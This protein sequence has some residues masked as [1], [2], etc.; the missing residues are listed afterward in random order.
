MKFFSRGW[1]FIISALFIWCVQFC[2]PF[3]LLFGDNILCSKASHFMLWLKYESEWNVC[4]DDVNTLCISSNFI[5]FGMTCVNGKKSSVMIW[6]SCVN[7]QQ[8]CV[9]FVFFFR[10]I[11][12]FL[13]QNTRFEMQQN[14]SKNESQYY[15]W[16]QKTKRERWQ[17][18]F[19]IENVCYGFFLQ[20]KFCIVGIL[21]PQYL[22][23]H[24]VLNH[25]FREQQRFVQ[26]FSTRM[27]NW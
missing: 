1:N 9:V 13:R 14:K 17:F 16:L 19:Y 27:K 23:H 6:C 5:L 7:R 15:K 8:I 11:S 25:V 24:I 22:K 4:T 21:I 3:L 18:F 20:I 12:R 26:L 10:K 2:F